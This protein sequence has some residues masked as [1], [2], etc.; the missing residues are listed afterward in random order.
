MNRRRFLLAAAVVTVAVGSLWQ[1]ALEA[2]RGQLEANDL[3]SLPWALLPLAF[4]VAGAGILWERPENLIGRLLLLPAFA[5]LTDTPVNLR[6]ESVNPIRD[7]LDPALFVTL[8]IDNISWLFLIFPIFHLL[9]V[10]PTGRLLS[11]W[12]R[13]VVGLELAMIGLLTGLGA[14]ATRVGPLADD[15]STVGPWTMA[16]PIGFVDPAIFGSRWFSI[17]WPSGLVVLVVVTVAAIAIRYR[18]SGEI[19]RHQIKWLFAAAG[20]FGLVYV[21]LFALGAEGDSGWSSGVLGLSLDLIPV[22]VLVAILR[23]RLF[24]ID[25]LISRTVGYALVAALA[26]AIYA[27]SVLA[28]SALLP[29]GANDL[30]VAAATLAAFAVIRPLRRATAGWVDRRF[31][32]TRYDSARTV[33][34]TAARLSSRLGLDDVVATVTDVT[35]QALHPEMATVWIRPLATV[36]TLP[37]E[38]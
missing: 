20:M 24:D 10:F 8:L 22:A 18:R 30:A 16:N 3:W 5:S 31:D 4:A 38:P 14:F 37:R 2:S 21:G 15:G 11:R 13:L 12:W 23:Y 25:R 36:V 17:G 1:V 9:L 26:A 27:G 28:V 29:E 19:E 33:G 7:R 35:H 34:D 6:L 32:R